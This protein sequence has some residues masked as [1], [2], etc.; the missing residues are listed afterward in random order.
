MEKA[1]QGIT[2]ANM[3]T[4]LEGYIAA[5]PERGKDPADM[6]K[7]LGWLKTTDVDQAIKFEA[8]LPPKFDD[9]DDKTKASI[10]EFGL[11]DH[12]R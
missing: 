4:I 6:R 12:Y 9:L 8:I 10:I 2:L 1:T 7:V 3:S 5:F 11:R